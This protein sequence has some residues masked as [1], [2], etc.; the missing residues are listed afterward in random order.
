M[1]TNLGI[2]RHKDTTVTP[3]V[4]GGTLAI[5]TEGNLIYQHPINYGSNYGKNAYIFTAAEMG[6]AKTIT[7]VEVYLRSWDTPVSFP[8][9]VIKIGHVTQSEFDLDPDMNFADLSVSGFITAKPSFTQSIP[10]NGVWYNIT[11]NTP[12][13]YNGVN[14]LLFVWENNWATTFYVTGGSSYMT[15]TN[16]AAIKSS[17]TFPVS[18]NGTRSSNRIVIKFHY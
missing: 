3:P 1:F 18:G 11:F 13:V 10:N 15:A 5:G 12:F 7:G 16:R 2:L 17:G 8:N 4:T 14:N 9:Q 6:A